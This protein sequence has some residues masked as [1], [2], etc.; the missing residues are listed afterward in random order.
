MLIQSIQ[1][2]TVYRSIIKL[3]PDHALTCG[4]TRHIEAGSSVSI[5][6]TPR[7]IGTEEV[8]LGF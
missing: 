1:W 3:D 8:L 5:R 7:K 4:G 6:H 2:R